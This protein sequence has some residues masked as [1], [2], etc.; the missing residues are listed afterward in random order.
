MRFR[1][2]CL[3]DG[4]GPF[5]HLANGELFSIVRD[6][7]GAAPCRHRCYQRKRYFEDSDFLEFHESL[8]RGNRCH[9][10]A[11]KETFQI[12]P[13]QREYARQ[14]NF[15]KIFTLGKLGLERTKDSV[16]PSSLAAPL[17]MKIDQPLI[18]S[19]DAAFF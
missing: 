9:R 19:R 14:Y 4:Y 10:Y 2:D 13:E 5:G 12:T 7:N 15:E 6:I 3:F 8:L 11:P 18:S 16:I 1:N 17:A